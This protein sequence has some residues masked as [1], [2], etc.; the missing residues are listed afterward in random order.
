MDFS[1]NDLTNRLNQINFSENEYI[2][3][4]SRE[5]IEPD[6]NGKIFLIP[7]DS[8]FYIDGGEDHIDR[9]CFSPTIDGCIAGLQIHEDEIMHVYAYPVTES[10]ETKIYRANVA[11]GEKTHELNTFHKTRVLYR[12]TIKVNEDSSWE[13]L[14]CKTLPENDDLYYEFDM[15]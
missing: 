14:K 3:H 6:E 5:Y 8:D 13:F 2:Y 12:G 1:L 11:N 7:S 9:N 15:R 10:T 4:L